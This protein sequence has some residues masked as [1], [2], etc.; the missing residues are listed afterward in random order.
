MGPAAIRIKLLLTIALSACGAGG[1][2]RTDL[3]AHLPGAPNLP[4]DTLPGRPSRVSTIDEAALARDAVQP[5][6]LAELLHDS[7]FIVGSERS[8]SLGAGRV[9]SAIARVLLFEDPEGATRY[10]DWLGGHATDVLGTA[11]REVPPDL[12]GS[13]LFLHEPTGCCHAET[14]MFLA[15][16]QRGPRVLSLLAVGPRVSRRAVAALASRFDSTV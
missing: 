6:P 9:R 15:A 8:F 4:A 2:P 3:P 5:V 11:T 12:T 13:L 1:S 14:S 10:L 16:W 7:G